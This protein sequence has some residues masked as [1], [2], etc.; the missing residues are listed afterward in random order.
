MPDPA[1]T[2]V[3]SLRDLRFAWG[4]QPVLDVGS[5][6]VRR[7]ERVF[8]QGP[9]GSGKSTLLGL[10]GGVLLPNSGDVMV[11]GERLNGLSGSRRDAF[12]VAHVGFVFQMFNLL[13][14]LSVVENVLLPARFSKERRSRALAH[15]QSL[16]NEALRL[17]GALG[18]TDADLLGRRVTELSVGQ[19]QRVAVARALLG[20]PELI[21]ADEP[22]SSLDADLK[23]Q[24]LQLLFKECAEAGATVLFVSHDSA[25]GHHFDRTLHMR[26]INRV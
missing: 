6:E 16:G 10:I 3:V 26:E 24:F 18:L 8:I 14:Y 2:S 4:R 23:E 17:L 9:S 11:L 13:P 22:T 1:A 19:Q 7:G 15:G 21:V 5:L 12:R 20:S 25:L